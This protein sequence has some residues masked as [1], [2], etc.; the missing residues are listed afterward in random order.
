MI[1]DFGAIVGDPPQKIFG[2]AVGDHREKT[3]PVGPDFIEG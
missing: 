3:M 1:N 2:T